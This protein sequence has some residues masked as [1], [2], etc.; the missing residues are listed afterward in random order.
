M[1]HRKNQC[2]RQIG[3]TARVLEHA[4]DLVKQGFT[5]YVVCAN[6]DS[7][8]RMLTR[9]IQTYTVNNEN[10]HFIPYTNRDLVWTN[11]ECYIRGMTKKTAILFDQSTFDCVIANLRKEIEDLK[12]PWSVERNKELQKYMKCVI[13]TIKY[14]QENRNLR[15]EIEDLKDKNKQPNYKAYGSTVGFPLDSNIVSGVQIPRKEINQVV[16]YNNS[17]L[18]SWVCPFKNGLTA[19]NSFWFRA[20]EPIPCW[21]IEKSRRI[22]PTVN[23]FGYY[24][25]PTNHPWSAEEKYE[26]KFKTEWFKAEG[27]IPDS[28]KHLFV[29]KFVPPEYA[30]TDETRFFD[31]T[32]LD[33]QKWCYYYTNHKLWMRLKTK[34]DEGD[35]NAAKTK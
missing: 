34:E 3:N 18:I 11:N 17:E 35:A 32:N 33:H 6:Y 1:D 2:N 26:V 31:H 29:Y 10:V 7:C 30:P 16:T 24:E 28:L 14:E 9:F 25:C 4:A 5:V 15:K 13:D 8:K 27:E 19:I 23:G 22:I 20:T 12:N 21:M